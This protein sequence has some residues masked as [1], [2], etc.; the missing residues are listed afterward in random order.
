MKRAFTLAEVLITLGIIGIVAAITI[1]GLI[2]SHTNKVAEVRLEEFYSLM[3]QAI[4]RAEYDYEERESWFQDFFD[5]GEDGSLNSKQWLETY[6]APYVKSLGVEQKD[7][8]AILRFLNGSAVEIATSYGRDWTFFPGDVEK[9]KKYGHNNYW[10]YIGTCAFAFHWNPT[11]GANNW[12]YTFQPYSF[13][14]ESLDT[15]KNHPNYGCNST[16]TA[17]GGNWRAYCTRLIQLNGWKIP[18]DYPFK[19]HV[20]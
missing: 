12:S 18:S 4:K 6:I 13:G 10:E 17:N 3:N 8:R 15:L 14:G 11:K 1:P 16:S 20:F 5:T 9:C 2:Q 19:V 7:G